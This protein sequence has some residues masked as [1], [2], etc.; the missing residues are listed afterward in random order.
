MLQIQPF[1]K[2]GAEY[3]SYAKKENIT[4]EAIEPSFFNEDKDRDRWYETCG[5]VSSVHG[6]FID[7]NP[8]S[9]DLLFRE[10]SERRCRQS[11][12][13]AVKCGAENVV[14]HSSCFPFIRG[15]YLDNWVKICAEFYQKIADEYKLNIFIENSPDI[16]PGPICELMKAVNNPRMGVCLDIGHSMYSSTSVSEWVSV[17]GPYVG[18]IH[19][20]D[21]MGKYDD[22]LALGDGVIDWFEANK[23]LSDLCGNIPV[24]LEVGNLENIKKS[25]DFLRINGLFGM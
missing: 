25:V 18:Y 4:F 15:A 11:C 24:T 2:N 16:D 5:L 9:G 19:L 8:A 3:I 6:A 1:Y 21:N 17:L 22:H 10:L 7:V 12:E 20:S 13:I 23:I 14:F